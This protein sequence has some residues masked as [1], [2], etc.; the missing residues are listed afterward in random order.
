MLV[1]DTE[2]H[3]AIFGSDGEAVLFFRTPK[4]AAKRSCLSLIP[5]KRA[6]LATSVRARIAGAPHTYRD[7]LRS[8]LEAAAALLDREKPTLKLAAR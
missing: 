4:E 5:P 7:R 8:M 6:R 1:A 3:R 2:D